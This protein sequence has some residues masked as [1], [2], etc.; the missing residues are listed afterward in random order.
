MK[1]KKS[2]EAELC[3]AFAQEAERLG[4]EA[5]PEVSG[6]DLLLVATAD[7]K[8]LGVLTGDQVGVQAKM[9]PNVEVL[10]QALHYSRYRASPHYRAV[11]LPGIKKT[12]AEHFY[13]VAAALSCLVLHPHKRFGWE[14]V[15]ARIPEDY[16]LHYDTPCWVPPY[17]IE[18]GGMASPMPVSAWKLRAIRFCLKYADKPFTYRELK[19][20]G[21]SYTRFVRKGWLVDTKTKAGRALLFRLSPDAVTP[22][23]KYADLTAKIREKEGL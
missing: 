7:V 5:H 10:G 19:A 1:Q 2:P 18:T 22:D 13:A 3:T 12:P 21:L 17:R 4:W 20:A 11:L 23:K 14:R 16:R 6:W 9:H 8:T 15:L